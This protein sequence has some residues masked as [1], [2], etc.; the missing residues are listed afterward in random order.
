MSFVVCG[1]LICIIA[2]TIDNGKLYI[3]MIG[4]GAEIDFFLN[5]HEKYE[6]YINQVFVKLVNYFSI[7]TYIY[8][9]CFE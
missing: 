5:N 3:Y 4:R 9:I 2:H 1:K 6:I 7:A 8:L